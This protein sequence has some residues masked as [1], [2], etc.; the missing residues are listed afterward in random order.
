VRT[1]RTAFATYTTTLQREIAMYRRLARAFYDPSFLDLFLEP[2]D[3]FALRNAVTALLAG[4]AGQQ[5]GAAGRRV[6]HRAWLFWQAY[7]LHRQFGKR[8]VRGDGDP[9]LPSA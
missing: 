2:T 8:S 6:H 7:A 9:Q 3:R 1:Q 5:R 4:H